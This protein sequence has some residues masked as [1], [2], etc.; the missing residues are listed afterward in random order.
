MHRIAL[1]FLTS[2]LAVAGGAHAAGV[3]SLERVAQT[4][5]SPP[6]LPSHTQKASASPKVVQ[7]RLVN[8]GSRIGIG[9]QAIVSVLNGQGLRISSPRLGKIYTAFSATS[10]HFGCAVS[11]KRLSR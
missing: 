1:A 4:L 8:R 7:V 2:L 9:G 6:L 11:G 5:V 10:K 3:D